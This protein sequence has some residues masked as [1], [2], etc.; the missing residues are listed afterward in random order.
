[1]I[2]KTN[3]YEGEQNSSVGLFFFKRIGISHNNIF[4]S[5]MLKKKN[6]G[7]KDKL[8]EVLKNPKL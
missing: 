8:L 3:Y 4:I 1:M 2:L 5:I 6:F 7:N